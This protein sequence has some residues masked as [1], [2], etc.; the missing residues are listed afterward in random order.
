MDAMKLVSDFAAENGWSD[1]TALIVVCGFID[2]LFERMSQT[3]QDI[4]GMF[5]RYLD[6][7]EEEEAASS[8]DYEYRTAEDCIQSGLHLTNVDEDGYCNFCGT[9]DE[10]PY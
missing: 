10:L 4:P 5:T 8:S 7:R 6:E 9:Q 1:T 2:E 3:S